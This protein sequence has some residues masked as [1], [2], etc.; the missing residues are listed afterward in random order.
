MDFDEFIS[1]LLFI[2]IAI[3]DVIRAKFRT[4]FP[5]KYQHQKTV[6]ALPYSPFCEKVFWAYDRCK[7]AYDTRAVFQGFFPTTLMEFSAKSVPIVID[8][9]NVLK[10]SKDV[11]SALNEEGHVWLYPTSL[12]RELES[13]FGDDFG[14][15]VARIVYYHLFSTSKGC[16]LLKRVWKVDVSPLEQALCDPVFPAVRWAMMSGLGFERLPEFVEEVDKV[17][18]RVSELLSDG[19]KY[20]CGTPEITA[21]DI[22]F[23][24]L[25]YPL[26]LP[27]EKATAFLGWDDKLPE[28]FRNEVRT[29]RETPAGK[30]VLRLYK[31]ERHL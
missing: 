25:A 24:S 13:E 22:T 10:D 14:K 15:S 20:L 8:N 5:V 27:E 9:N 11:L 12:V 28:N 1:L 21:A 16:I 3:P 31:E 6:V 18:T 17:F 4:Y 19:R 23:A 30:F 2:I 29:R 26:I 7:I